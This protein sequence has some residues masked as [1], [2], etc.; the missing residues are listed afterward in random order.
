MPNLHVIPRF[1]GL[2]DKEKVNAIERFV[3]ALW[4][5]VESA[6][7]NI[8]SD[9]LS[10][11]LYEKL[12]ALGVDINRNKTENEENTQ[13]GKQG[14]VDIMSIVT[15]ALFKNAVKGLLNFRVNFETGELEYDENIVEN[16]GGNT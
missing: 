10:S 2:D 7:S 12:I 16:E 9:N 13:G 6:L 4:E 15:S 1:N 14:E 5:D 8:G 11:E 3:V